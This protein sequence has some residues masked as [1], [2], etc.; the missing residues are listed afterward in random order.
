[1]ET[2]TTEEINNEVGK[3]WFLAD[4]NTLAAKLIY[5]AGIKTFDEYLGEKDQHDFETVIHIKEKPKGLILR[6]AKNFSAK[7]TAISYKNLK[8]VS[9]LKLDRYSIIKINTFEDPIYFGLDNYDTF[10]I[11]N[12][13]KGLREITFE[14]NAKSEIPKEVK[15]KL[16]SFLIKNTFKLNHYHT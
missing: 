10:E 8:Q 1:M 16:E 7:E 14:E 13:F 12:Y 15:E 4:D 3:V 6:L 5:I 9:L 11:V 2:M